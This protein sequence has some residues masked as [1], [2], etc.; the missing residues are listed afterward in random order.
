MKLGRGAKLGIATLL[1]LALIYGGLKSYVY[2]QSRD[3]LKQ[4]VALASPF[5]SIQYGGIGSTLWQG[6]VHVMDV[7]FSPVN[8][9]DSVVIER[10]TLDPGGL[11]SLLTLSRRLEAREFPASLLVDFQ[12]VTVDLN[13]ELMRALEKFSKGTDGDTQH[14][15]KQSKLPKRSRESRTETC[16]RPCEYS[17]EHHQPRSPPI[18]QPSRDRI[19]AGV[20]NGKN[21]CQPRIARIIQIK[22]RFQRR[23][24]NGND[25]AIHIIEHQRA[26]NNRKNDPT[27]AGRI[28]KRHDPSVNAVIRER[29]FCT[30]NEIN[31]GAICD[32]RKS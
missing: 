12:S 24:E 21:V 2:V 31:F 30:A 23:L 9:D 15:A 27:A 26:K 14:P 6:A 5:V 1:G 11:W 28:Q 29:E 16:Q 13:G 20:T 22:F 4:V 3:A 10:L 25:L 17:C 19:H 8:M 18:H 7:K 32:K